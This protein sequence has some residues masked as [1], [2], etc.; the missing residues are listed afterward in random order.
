M[1]SCIRR[2]DERGAI[3]DVTYNSAESKDSPGTDFKSVPDQ[4]NFSLM[5]ICV[6]I[7]HLRNLRTEMLHQQ[8]PNNQ[9][10]THNRGNGNCLPKNPADENE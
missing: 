7:F 6:L 5:V 4:N 2:N 1:D 10:Q 9:N 8:P 3:Y